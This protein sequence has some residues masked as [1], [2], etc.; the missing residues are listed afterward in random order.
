L[1]KSASTI[2]LPKP[3]RPQPDMRGISRCTRGAGFATGGAEKFSNLISLCE[4]LVTGVP[5]GDTDNNGADHELL[6]GWLP[7]GLGRMLGTD[8]SKNRSSAHAIR[9][10]RQCSR[11]A[12]VRPRACADRNAKS[13]PKIP[14]ELCRRLNGNGNVKAR[15]RCR[16]DGYHKHDDRVRSH[17]LKYGCVT[18]E[19]R[20][21]PNGGTG[22]STR[23][24][25]RRCCSCKRTVR[26][27]K[28]LLSKGRRY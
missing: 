14:P 22:G 2:D 8:K 27:S 20:P 23:Y 12:S 17:A 18:S 28:T 25:F 5:Q 13:G 1:F 19:H 9:T 4:N 16:S 11:P 7:D 15:K 3:S 24:Q 6:H 10:K 21:A 26:C